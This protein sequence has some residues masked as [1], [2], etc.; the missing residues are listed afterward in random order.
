MNPNEKKDVAATRARKF[1]PYQPEFRHDT[2]VGWRASGKSVSVYAKEIGVHETSLYEW[3]RKEESPLPGVAGGGAPRAPRS[4]EELEAEL[5]S[6]RA[7]LERVRQQRDILK[8]TLGIISE[9][10]PSAMKGSKP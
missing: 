3:I 4:V 7:E 10:P 9:A 5:I 6:T 8:K 1:A 2:V